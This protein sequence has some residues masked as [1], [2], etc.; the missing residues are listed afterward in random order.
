M[1]D[2]DRYLHTHTLSHRQVQFN[3]QSQWSIGVV[4]FFSLTRILYCV[5]LNCIASNGIH[6]SRYR[7]INIITKVS[8]N[9][10]NN[11]E[12]NHKTHLFQFMVNEVC[13]VVANDLR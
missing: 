3:I 8:N 2:I 12:T 7:Y 5:H 1:F 9:N 13:V 11:K 6:T 10:S 4:L